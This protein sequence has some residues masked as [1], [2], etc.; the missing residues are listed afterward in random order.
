M[1]SQLGSCRGLKGF[2]SRTKIPQSMHILEVEFQ[3]L[4]RAD[5]ERALVNRLISGDMHP[6]KFE[7]AILPYFILSAQAILCDNISVLAFKANSD[8]HLCLCTIPPANP[9]YLTHKM[10]VRVR[11]NLYIFCK[12]AMELPSFRS[13]WDNSSLCL[14][15]HF[16]HALSQFFAVW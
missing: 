7:R 10:P 4:A 5:L 3:I 14:C 15:Y 1:Y 13:R 11:R 6:I 12:Y 2:D 8:H 9:S 16:K